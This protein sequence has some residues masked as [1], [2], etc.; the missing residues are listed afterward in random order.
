MPAPFDCLTRSGNEAVRIGPIEV[1]G[2]RDMRGLSV[3][4]RPAD[5]ESGGTPPRLARLFDPSAALPEHGAAQRNGIS[6]N[7]NRSRPRPVQPLL[8]YD[9]R[10]PGLH[11]AVG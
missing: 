4:N 11:F 1:R 10:Y 9:I 7:R 3:A 5:R 8:R 6:R 2:R